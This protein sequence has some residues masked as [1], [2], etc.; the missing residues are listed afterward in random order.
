[1]REDEDHL[2][3]GGEATFSYEEGDDDDGDSDDDCDY[4]SSE[5]N[6]HIRNNNGAPSSEL[7]QHFL[8]IVIS[9]IAAIIA[10]SYTHGGYN[11]WKDELVKD[12]ASFKQRFSTVHTTNEVYP[13]PTIDNYAPFAA[14]SMDGI[15][16]TKRKDILDR[17]MNRETNIQGDNSVGGHEKARNY[18]RTRSLSFCDVNAPS[19]STNNNLVEMEFILPIVPSVRVLHSYYLA[20]ALKVDSNSMVYDYVVSS[21][22]QLGKDVGSLGS[23]T[24]DTILN[25]IDT[26]MATNNNMKN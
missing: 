3:I 1:M 20:D 26:T 9:I 13:T 12:W 23:Y 17:A 19:S 10:H 21:S 5:E 14:P 15:P 7:K 22:E 11:V 2:P 6:N 24:S 4:D 25:E 18:R 16:T 8:A